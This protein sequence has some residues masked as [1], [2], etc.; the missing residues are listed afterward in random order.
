MGR[1]CHL[2]RPLDAGGDIAADVPTN[3]EKKRARFRTNRPSGER[4]KRE[5]VNEN[6]VTSFETVSARR[7]YRRAEICHGTFVLNV[8]PPEDE[9]TPPKWYPKCWRPL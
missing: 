2:F 7:P 5:I 9:R 8:S 1:G 4:A 3:A 6:R